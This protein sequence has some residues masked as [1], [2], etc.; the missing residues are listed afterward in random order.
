M[1]I[2]GLDPGI[3]R[4][5]YGVVTRTHGTFS[6]VAAGVIHTPAGD[7]LPLRL[8]TIEKTLVG[9][10]AEHDPGCAVIERLVPGPGRT[11]SGVAEARGVALLL[12]GKEN[13]P[14]TEESPKAVK[15]LTTRHGAA[16]KMQMRKT[17]QRLLMMD[18]LP[19]ADAADALALAVLGRI[20]PETA[21]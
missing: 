21:R 12:L 17:I 3:A 2:L 1:K 19:P 10:I 9:V 5:G 15:A 20:S 6:Y 18:S 16:T 14:V 8:A 13:I 11:L 7:P 4:F